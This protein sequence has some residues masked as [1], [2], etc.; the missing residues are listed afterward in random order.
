MN[1]F[2][3][4]LIVALYLDDVDLKGER[5]VDNNVSIGP[6]DPQAMWPITDYLHN[7]TGYPVLKNIYGVYYDVIYATSGPNA[8]LGKLQFD[9]AKNSYMKFIN[10]GSLDGAHAVTWAFFVYPSV[11]Q[12]AV[13]MQYEGNGTYPGMQLLLNTDGTISLRIYECTIDKCARKTF[14]TTNTLVLPGKW[15]LLALTWNILWPAPELD[16]FANGKEDQFTITDKTSM[17]NMRLSGDVLF[18]VSDDGKD[19][20]TGDMSC[21][22]FY[23]T[24]IIGKTQG[25]IPDLCDPN[26]YA[27]PEYGDPIG[28]IAFYNMMFPQEST[29]VSTEMETTTVTEMTSIDDFTTNNGMTTINEMTSLN[30]ITTINGMTAINEMTSFRVANMTTAAPQVETTGTQT[31]TLVSSTSFPGPDTFVPVEERVQ[32]CCAKFVLI[33]KQLT[34]SA[35]TDT[36]LAGS[37]SVCTRHCLVNVTCKAVSLDTVSGICSLANDVTTTIHPTSSAYEKALDNNC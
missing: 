24:S 11:A 9:A 17:E 10:D 14:K 36:T 13:L 35:P 2:Y 30:D 5:K 33:G 28:S 16:I 22:Q 20:F 32:D 25:G 19:Y 6:P 37:W 31:T 27:Y 21:F 18:G 1:I 3:I 15:T 8:G 23:N 26:T 12:K 29:V 7:N 4:F 34:V